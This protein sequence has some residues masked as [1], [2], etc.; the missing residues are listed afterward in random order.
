MNH[1][2]PTEMDVDARNFIAA[3]LHGVEGA[4]PV[5]SSEPLVEIGIIYAAGKGTALPCVNWSGAAR[6]S[7]TV[8]LHFN[9]VYKTATLA[10]GGKVTVSGANRSTF[11]FDMSDTI[12]ALILR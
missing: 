6:P 4:V 7:F 11:V 2:I 5:S 3:P 12:D 9:V 1:F 8:T 10:S